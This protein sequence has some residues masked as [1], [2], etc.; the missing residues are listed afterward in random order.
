[1]TAPVV[2]VMV[3]LADL[4]QQLTDL[5]DAVEAQQRTLR[6]LLER[7]ATEPCAGCLAVGSTPRIP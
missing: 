3:V 5:T 7:H 4:Q 6:S 1:V 2:D